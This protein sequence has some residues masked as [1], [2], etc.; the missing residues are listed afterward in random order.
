MLKGVAAEGSKT[1]KYN[2]I[3]LSTT[4]PFM[5]KT[6]KVRK[7]LTKGRAVD[8][9]LDR[10]FKAKSGLFQNKLLPL[11]PKAEA[12]EQETRPLR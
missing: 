5:F 4:F 3:Y 2:M 6:S 9:F 12:S 8:S 10:P 11:D 1:L 7:N